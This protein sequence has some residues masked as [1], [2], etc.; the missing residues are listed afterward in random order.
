MPFYQ[1]GFYNMTKQEFN[2]NRSVWKHKD[3][4]NENT[5]SVILDTQ[6]VLR[7]LFY[8]E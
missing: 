2:K 6:S 8:N 3:N 4:T 7:L 5:A 1:D